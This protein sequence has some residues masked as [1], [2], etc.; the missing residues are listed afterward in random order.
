[1]IF[2][3][4]LCLSWS[5]LWLLVSKKGYEG[6]QIFCTNKKKEFVF[7]LFIIYFVGYLHLPHEWNL[8]IHTSSTSSFFVHPPILLLCS[9]LVF[10]FNFDVFISQPHMHR[11]KSQPRCRV[12]Q[13]LFRI[14]SLSLALSLFPLFPLFFNCNTHTPK[15]KRLLAY[16]CN[17]NNYL[18]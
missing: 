4:W 1:M 7:F 8:F 15:M 9:I 17:V 11:Q 5:I 12:K 10:I 16:I 13:K 2:S 14:P 3:W 18:F 6:I